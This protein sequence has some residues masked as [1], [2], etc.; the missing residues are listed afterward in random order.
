MSTYRSL[1]KRN[2]GCKGKRR[3]FTGYWTSQIPNGKQSQQK[4]PP[5]SSCCRSYSSVQWCSRSMSYH[6]DTLRKTDKWLMVCIYTLAV[7]VPQLSCRLAHTTFP[8]RAWLRRKT[9]RESTK[10]RSPYSRE[11]G[12]ERRRRRRGSSKTSCAIGF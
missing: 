10:M 3:I 9:R 4:A 11:I 6:H 1:F 2:I 7:M 12:L 5:R 8:L